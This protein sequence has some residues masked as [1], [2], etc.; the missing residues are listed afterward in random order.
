MNW[1]T[2]V[3]PVATLCLATATHAQGPPRGVFD[4]LVQGALDRNRELLAARERIREAQGLLR[5]AGVRPNPTIEVEGATGRP[6]GTQGE[7]EYTAG[8]FYPVETGGKRSKR[9]RVAGLSVALA[10]AQVDERER[11]LAY[12]IKTRAL[13]ALT[14]REKASTLEK[15]LGVTRQ[16]YQ[17]TE[18][19]IREGDAPRLDAQLLLVE[20]NR[21]EAQ[22]TSTAGRAEAA[23]LELR[24]L[25][26]LASAEKVPL[27]DGIPAESRTPV[28]EAL[29]AKALKERADVRIA[30]LLEEQGGSEVSLAEAQG[31]PDVTLSARYTHRTT[32]FDQFGLTAAGALTPLRD[33]ANVVT[34]GAS[35]PLFTRKNNQGNIQAATARASGARLQREFLESTVPLEVEAAYRRWSA[36]KNTLAVFDS[37][38]IGQSETNLTVVRQAYQLGQLRLLDV[39]NEQRRLVDTELAYIDAKAELARSVVELE[40]AIGASLP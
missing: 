7:E 36:A 28:L 27:G 35:I 12:D 3:L 18:G 10:Q 2:I 22:R 26:G 20:Q 16:A 14:D 21:T 37:A 25:V 30:R 4:D 17:L 32:Q 19:R 11:R 5:Q 29:Q 8:Y 15:L 33:R 9:I 6:L 38:V 39:L 40:R 23:V 24:R 13:E 1:K 31:S 34:F